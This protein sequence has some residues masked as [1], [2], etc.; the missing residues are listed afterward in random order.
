MTDVA[1]VFPGQGAQAVGM[2]QE[3]YNGSPEAKAIFDE[4]NRGL[5]LS[6]TNFT[7]F[8]LNFLKSIILYGILRKKID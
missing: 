8:L 6:P 3:F 2:G 7:D 4:A 1:L 5:V